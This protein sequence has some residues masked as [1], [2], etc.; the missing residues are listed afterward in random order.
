MHRVLTGREG[1][2]LCHPAENSRQDLPFWILVE[3]G[4]CD[5][6]RAKK[7]FTFQRGDHPE[8]LSPFR[9][10]GCLRHQRRHVSFLGLFRG[11]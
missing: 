7:L 9:H 5:S 2:S 6:N 4:L 11:A 1:R 3:S 8:I 10:S